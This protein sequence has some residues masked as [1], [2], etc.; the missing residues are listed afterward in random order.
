MAA[1]KLGACPVKDVEVT[2]G[3]NDGQP[4]LVSQALSSE[5]PAAYAGIDASLWRPVAE[6]VLEAAYEATLLTAAINSERGRSNIVLL[7]QLGGGTFGDDSK[8]IE[9]TSRHHELDVRARE[10]WLN[11]AVH[12]GVGKCASI[13]LRSQSAWAGMDFEQEG[14]LRRRNFFGSTE[15][16]NPLWHPAGQVF[17]WG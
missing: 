4:R 1:H 12:E 16:G 6:L 8:W 10:L 5:L 2:E 3:T 17:P 9:A 11:S 14:L 13:T 15:L 7:T